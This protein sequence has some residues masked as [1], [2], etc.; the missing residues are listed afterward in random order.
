MSIE[1]KPEW[2]PDT[3]HQ[4][5]GVDVREAVRRLAEQGLVLRVLDPAPRGALFGADHNPMRIN[6]IAGEDDRVSAVI[7]RRGAGGLLER[8]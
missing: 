2:D 8:F 4:L 3:E 5:V 1:R 7:R 6:V